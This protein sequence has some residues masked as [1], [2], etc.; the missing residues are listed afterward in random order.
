[1]TMKLVSEEV[2]EL[3]KKGDISPEEAVRFVEKVGQQLVQT[4]TYHPPS[5]DEIKH[6]YK[7][8]AELRRLARDS[9]IPFIS[10]DVMDRI[11]LYPGFVLVG[12]VSG[13][14]KSTTAANI[15]AGFAS[16]VPAGK[17]LVLTN[18]ENSADVYDRIACAMTGVGFAKYRHGAGSAKEREAV[19]EESRRL[20]GRVVV[21]EGSTSYDMTCLEDVQAA[22]VHAADGGYGIALLDYLQTVNWSREHT[23]MEPVRVSKE[24]GF[25]LKDYSRRVTIPVVVF[26][27]LR[28][29]DEAPDFKSRIQNDRTIYDHAVMAIEIVPDP[30]AKTTKFAI[31]KDRF[32]ESQGTDIEMR[33]EGGRYVPV[34]G[35]L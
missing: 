13:H 28:P 3:I 16:N 34:G 35:T 4:R 7:Q 19:E 21:E 8:N 25:F 30:E 9:E 15:M 31:H 10:L 6:R 18:E 17:A 11:K 24:L 27:Q 22:L 2:K 26:A 12:G 29:R 5:I 32:G 23:D 14:G 20:M 1:M 33:Y